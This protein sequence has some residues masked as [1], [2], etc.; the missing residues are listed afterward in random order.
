MAGAAVG[1]G[2]DYDTLTYTVSLGEEE[3]GVGFR[4]GS[5]LAEELNKFFAESYENGTMMEIAETYGV[6]A[7]II[8]Q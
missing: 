1:E 3:F 5:E 4:K 8:P 2:T 6:Q 7:S